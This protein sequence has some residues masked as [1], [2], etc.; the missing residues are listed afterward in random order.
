[1]ITIRIVF[2]SGMASPRST[3][4]IKTNE[5]MK[6]WN[7]IVLLPTRYVFE[8]E[9]EILFMKESS[10]ILLFFQIVHVLFTICESKSMHNVLIYI[11]RKE[12]YVV[13]IISR[14]NKY[15]RLKY[16]EKLCYRSS[17]C[18]DLIITY[19]IQDL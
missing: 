13:K 18:L 14:K 15:K 8:N 6:L 16:F 17:W 4:N 9:I 10:I 5:Y 12:Y 7:Y 19:V 3:R 2:D 11:E 1:M